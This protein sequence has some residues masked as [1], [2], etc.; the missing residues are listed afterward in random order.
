MELFE[1]RIVG[2]IWGLRLFSPSRV[3][4]LAFW[5]RALLLDIWVKAF[6]RPARCQKRQ[7]ALFLHGNPKP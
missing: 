5:L 2:G 4:G 3:V 1:C 6:D 7:S